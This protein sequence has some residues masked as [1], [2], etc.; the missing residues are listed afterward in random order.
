MLHKQR[1]ITLLSGLFLFTTA[2]ASQFN[3][4]DT[5][6][7]KLIEQGAVVIGQQASDLINH[8]KEEY[9][10]LTP[11]QKLAKQHNEAQ[12]VLAEKNK[13][14]MDLNIEE[15]QLDV[16]LKKIATTKETCAGLPH[17]DKEAA[18]QMQKLKLAMMEFNKNLPKLP[19]QETTE[20]KKTEL[21]IENSVAQQKNSFSSMVVASFALA[22]T[23]TGKIADTI[24]DYSFGYITNLEYLK[25]SFVDKHSVGINRALVAATAVIITYA[26]YSL[27]KSKSQSDDDDDIFSD[28][29]DY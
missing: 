26:A 9:E 27:Y 24:A 16:H 23:K 18:E 13:I 10:I 12:L 14:L 29:F 17:N 25:G 1:Y 11:S 15:K 3:A 21:S 8:L 22:A 19:A 6:K 2:N 28:D 20:I 4:S 5:T 7:E